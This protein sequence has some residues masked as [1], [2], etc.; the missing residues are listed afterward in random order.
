MKEPEASKPPEYQSFEDLLRRVVAVP[1]KEVDRLT[2]E[3]HAKRKPRTNRKVA[4]A[5]T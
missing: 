2:A 4:P 5:H 1:K 3:E